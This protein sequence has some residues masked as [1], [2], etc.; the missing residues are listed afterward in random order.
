MSHPI[1]KKAVQI[2]LLI[3]LIICSNPSNADEWTFIKN[4]TG[5]MCNPLDPNA[6]PPT[7]EERRELAKIVQ[8]QLIED[9]EK[10]NG[11]NPLE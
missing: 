7:K 1:F 5:F 9:S 6:P 11:K 8:K 2:I 3:L 10:E 4:M